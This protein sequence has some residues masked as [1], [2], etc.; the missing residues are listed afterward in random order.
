MGFVIRFDT[1]DKE[2]L[3]SDELFDIGSIRYFSHDYLY[4]ENNFK[5]S[6]LGSYRGMTPLYDALVNA[7]AVLFIERVTWVL[8]KEKIDRILSELDELRKKNGDDPFTE[9]DTFIKQLTAIKLNHDFD[10]AWLLFT[11]D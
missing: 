6:P 9:Y 5:I 2:D 3:S 4:E 11:A 1:I 7:D 8:E 10:K